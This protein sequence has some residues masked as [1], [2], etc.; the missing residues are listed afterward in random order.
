MVES[1]VIEP[2]G[3]V[4]CDGRYRFEAPR[5]SVFA[6]NTGIIELF[7]GHGY[8]QAAADLVGFERIWVIFL[9]H[10]NQ[11]WRPKVAPP[12]APPDRRI[13][14][15]ATRSPHRPNRL[16]L[17]CVELDSV[18]GLV[19]KIRNFDMLDG[20]PVLDIKPYIP[21][22]DAFPDA[23][24]GWPA[25]VEADLWQLSFSAAVREK[26]DFILERGGPDLI[27]FC[28]IQLGCA[29]L[30]ARRKR[31]FALPDGGFE[32]GCRVWRIAFVPDEAA[33]R[34]EVRDIR[35]NFTPAELAPDAPDRY[36]DLELH[37]A[38][39]ARFGRA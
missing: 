22:A 8:E 13:G 37:R 24:V 39:A 30:D 28:E 25:E 18:D 35:S 27:G 32:I 1:G 29:P 15:F 9:F 2:I 33:R 5:Q 20:T 6:S 16:G 26:R 34:I 7:P 36:G 17:S 19:L 23:A 3:R 21:R 10:L 12:V 4:C 38:F 11:T 14:V 31:L